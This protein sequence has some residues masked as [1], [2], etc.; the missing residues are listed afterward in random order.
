[1]HNNKV[2]SRAEIFLGDCVKGVGTRVTLRD[3]AQTRKRSNF[4]F[5]YLFIFFVGRFLKPTEYTTA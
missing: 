2:S 5:I 4:F 3:A 1:M